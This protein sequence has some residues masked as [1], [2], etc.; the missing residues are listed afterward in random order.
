MCDNVPL[1]LDLVKTNVCKTIQVDLSRVNVQR[2][3]S[4]YNVF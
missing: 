4:E 1:T 3:Y 2:V